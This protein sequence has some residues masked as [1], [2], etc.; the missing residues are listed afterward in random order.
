M[1]KS[2]MSSSYSPTQDPL[3]IPKTRDPTRGTMLQAMAVLAA[4]VAFMIWKRDKILRASPLPLAVGVSGLLYGM[5]Y[6]LVGTSCDFRMHYWTAVAAALL[7][8]SSLLILTE[9]R[10]ARLPETRTSA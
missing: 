3:L 1:G 4:T 6:F 9:S 5:A 8:V 10:L 7:V 2:S